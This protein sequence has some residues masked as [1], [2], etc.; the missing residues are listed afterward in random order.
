MS[1]SVSAIGKPASVAAKVQ[2]DLDGYRCTDPEEGV[3]QAAGVAILAAVNAQ[4][5]NSVVRVT[6]SG[7]QSP[8]Y[9]EKGQ[10]VGFQ[11]QLQMIVEPIY[12]FVE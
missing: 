4:S 7:H 9:D 3:K 11:N 2:K 5:A 10:T 8:I 1:W 6:A 12:G